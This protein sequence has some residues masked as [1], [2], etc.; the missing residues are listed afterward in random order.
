[1]EEEEEK[2]NNNNTTTTNNNNNNNNNFSR[3]LIP[4]ADGL[5]L[6]IAIQE[7]VKVDRIHS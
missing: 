1:M 5:H 7:W 2:K 4:L 6:H 3:T